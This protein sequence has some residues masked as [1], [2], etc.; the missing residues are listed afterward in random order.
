[1][2]LA[3]AFGASGLFSGMGF[4]KFGLLAATA[5][6]G[7]MLRRKISDKEAG[8]LNDLK[9]SGSSYGKGIPEIWGTM[10]V[11]GNMIWATD[12]EEEKHYYNS[13]GKDI[14]GKKKADKKGTPRFEYFA[15]FG[16]ALC[17]G[18]VEDLLRIWADGNLIYD[19]LNPDGYTDNNGVFHEVVGIGFTQHQDG[20]GKG[21]KTG[22]A[23]KGHDGDSGRFAYRFY[24]GSEDQQPDD[25]MK[26]KSIRACPAYRGLS[27]LFFERFKL[28]DF[29]NRTP[30]ITAE[31]L[32]R[33]KRH[34]DFQF[35]TDIVYDAL[36]ADHGWS[37]YADRAFFDP[38]RMRFYATGN[39]KDGKRMLRVYDATTAAETQQIDMASMVADDIP[40]ISQLG[41]QVGT[42]S[43]YVTDIIGLA[44]DGSLVA[45]GPTANSCPVYFID[46]NTYQIAASFGDISAALANTGDSIVKPVGCTPIATIDPLTKQLQL[47]TAIMSFQGQMYYFDDDNA[48]NDFALRFQNGTIPYRI[49]PGLPGITECFYFITENYGGSGYIAVWKR[50]FPSGEHSAEGD[51][52]PMEQVF[53]FPKDSSRGDSSLILYDPFVLSGPQCLGVIY[54]IFSGDPDRAGLYARKID[55]NS[56]DVVWTHE[57]GT[58]DDLKISDDPFDG[59]QTGCMQQTPIID[60]NKIVWLRG[61]VAWECDFFSRTA[62]R[63]PLPD[64]SPAALSGQMYW[65]TKAAVLFIS[66][67]S[68][69]GNRPNWCIG[70][71]D[72]L[73]QTGVSIKD[74]CLDMAD[75]VGIDRGLTNT[76]EM[77]DD[78]IIGYI[79][80]NPQP[81]RGVI[82]DLSK[83][84][85]FDVIESDNQLKFVSRGKNPILTIT[86]DDLGAV[87]DAPMDGVIEWYKETKVQEIDCPERVD[88]SF[89]NSEKEYENGTQGYKRP[90]SPMPVLQTREK[91]DLNL[92]IAMTP[93]TAKQ[94]AQKVCMSVWAERISHDF[95][96]PWTY[97]TLDPTDVVTF[98][99]D[100]G[101][102]FSDRLTKMDIGADYTLEVTAV[103]QTPS[104]YSS[105]IRGNRG[106]GKI[107]IPKPFDPVTFPLLWDI[108]YVEDID[109]TPGHLNVYWGAAA[110]GAGFKFALL[111]EQFG[112]ADWN[113]ADGVNQ[114]L[115]WG[116][117]R[118]VV[119]PPA[120][121]LFATDTSTQI[122]LF[123]AWNVSAVYTWESI[124]DADWP[125][126]D[127]AILIGDE[128][129]YFKEV[130]EHDDGS[131]TISTLIRGARGTEE[132]A[133]NHLKAN[134][135]W[136]LA[137]TDG[138]RE[139]AEEASRLNQSATFRTQG[140]GLLVGFGTTTTIPLTGAN[141]KPYAP[142]CLKRTDDT[143]ST[144]DV[145]VSWERRTRLGGN[146]QNGTDTVPLNEETE[147]YDA[148]VLSVPF[149]EGV[150]DP[151]N[152]STY[153]R[154]FPSLTS[155]H[156]DY[157]AANLA[158]DGLALTDDLYVVV[159]QRSAVV[160]RG[161]PGHDILYASVLS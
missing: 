136:A 120:N 98:E 44:Q 57:D 59:Y 11:T 94:M 158:T 72:R 93:D 46:P 156:F 104:T 37:T 122:T 97:I 100:N 81:A 74:I 106:G 84:F 21:Q 4:M 138:F 12:F 87:S 29:G 103:T 96:L 111:Q 40:V 17:A 101:L 7:F 63:Y 145:R 146:I 119:P 133:E 140:T 130:E 91:L 126:T 157:L 88:V 141:L 86:Q 109:D 161:F 114:D 3:V 113:N 53:Y 48:P 144:G 137:G 83:V 55:A 1:M 78:E 27:Y 65:S 5:V 42:T 159:Y 154:A 89:V 19:K 128:L 160:G 80:E 66:H 123:P 143:P 152:P 147:L 69:D 20:G 23:K 67:N 47:F 153:L 34:P 16:M 26:N 124:P 15:N 82:E 52:K 6:G 117:V 38:L 61:G 77:N 24:N 107:A 150:F 9:V 90:R 70:Y 110:Y 73:S 18:P 41:H 134:E 35:C 64:N 151:T 108:P 56:G 33:R 135:K 125:S 10:R 75:Q 8:K 45:I 102:E 92:P 36:D 14:T 25:F 51:S 30:T 132:A 95:V 118:R 155:P 149:A 121:G 127:N 28:A 31:V 112:S 139:R 115:I 148:Y 60:A 85:M 68:N 13:K 39:T 129:M 43:G 62:R 142:V 54:G 32:V 50:Y 71:L 2:Q 105:D 49:L 131:V 99:M 76:S 58:P 22:G 79:L 116:S